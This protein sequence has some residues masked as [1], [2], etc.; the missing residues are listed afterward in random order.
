MVRVQ[1]RINV[2]IS[3]GILALALY[4]AGFRAPLLTLAVFV[5][6]SSFS[7]ILLIMFNEYNFDVEFLFKGAKASDTGA[8]FLVIASSLSFVYLLS[9]SFVDV[10]LNTSTP[11]FELF[12]YLLPITISSILG[13]ALISSIIRANASKKLRISVSPDSVDVFDNYESMLNPLTIVIDNGTKNKLN[14]NVV[15]YFP[16]NVEAKLQNEV[17]GSKSKKEWQMKVD[18]NSVKVVYLFIKHDSEKL[19]H[20]KLILSIKTDKFDYKKVIDLFKQK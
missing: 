1:N 17:E 9:Q 11:Y 3:L 5:A 4:T 18:A 7:L 20:N 10:F 2:L 16:D 14:A 12:E 6:L 15:A 13:V 19:E 8:S